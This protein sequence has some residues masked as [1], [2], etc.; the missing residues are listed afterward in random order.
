MQGQDIQQPGQLQGG[1]GHLTQFYRSKQLALKKINK[2]YT[3]YS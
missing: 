1:R 2:V 3:I